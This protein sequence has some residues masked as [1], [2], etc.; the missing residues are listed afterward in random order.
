M[1]LCSADELGIS[2]PSVS[3]ILHQ[4][5]NAL[6]RPHI[7]RQ[8]LHFPLDVRQLQ[9]NKAHFMAIAGFPGV[10]GAIDGTHVRIIAPSEDEHAFV[11]FDASYNILDIVAKWPGAKHDSRILEESGLRLLFE[12][13]HINYTHKKTRSVVERGIGQMKRRFHVLHGEIRLTPEKASRII[14]MLLEQNHHQLL[15]DWQEQSLEKWR[16][17]LG[18]GGGRSLAMIAS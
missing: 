7:V 15:Q 5:V 6:G 3:R 14:T 17:D 1:Q 9:R 4:T 18:G 13:H 10:V 8:F 2:Q 11:V 12:R 16:E